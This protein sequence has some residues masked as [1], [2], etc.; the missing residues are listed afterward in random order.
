[1]FVE[2]SSVRLLQEKDCH[3]LIKIKIKMVSLVTAATANT[4]N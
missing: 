3:F 4:F 2:I 1:M